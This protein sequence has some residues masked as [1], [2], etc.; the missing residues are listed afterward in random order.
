MSLGRWLGGRARAGAA[1]GSTSK[2]APHRKP[3]LIA[4]GIEALESRCLPS[5]TIIDLGTLGGSESIG[6]ALN[7]SGQVTGVS[8]TAGDEFSHAFLYSGGSMTDI[9]TLNDYPNSGGYAIN[10]AGHVVGNSREAFLYDGSSLTD[11]GTLGGGGSSAFAVN[12]SDEV[13]GYSTIVGD[14]DWHAFLYAGGVMKNLGTFGGQYS[15][16]N[17]I[18][19]NEEVVGY[20]ALANGPLHAFY[21]N[22][23][24][25]ML[26]LGTLGG[27]QSFATA[28]NNVGQVV[29]YSETANGQNH[30]F[31]YTGGVMTDLGFSGHNWLAINNYGQVVGLLSSGHPFLY[32]DGVANDLNDL[33]PDGSGWLLTD[34][35]GINDAGQIVGYGAINNQTHA[36][37]MTPDDS[38]ARHGPTPGLPPPAGEFA[39]LAGA[40]APGGTGVSPGTALVGVWQL[41]AGPAQQPPQSANPMTTAALPGAGVAP[42]SFQLAS[43]P[44]PN[45]F[46]DWLEARALTVVTMKIVGEQ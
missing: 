44:Q 35:R 12:Q 29:G 24:V 6:F 28:I 30:V 43:S 11:L 10:D 45:P 1:D 21:Y 5:Y 4:L 33:L 39:W 7:N 23:T 2:R 14:A 17:G 13:V 41:N 36:F 31:I 38:S 15:V 8:R 20:A 46:A 26:D 37:L 34:A 22:A 25:G 16:A 3:L 19:D 32:A 9:G 40:G 27:L 42:V 18:N